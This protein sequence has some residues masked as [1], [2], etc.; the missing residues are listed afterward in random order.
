MPLKKS[1]GNM[2]PWVS[3]VHTHLGGECPH[4]CL[5]CYVDNPRWG[6]PARY[7]GALR[8]IEKEF[9]VDYGEGKTIF[10]ENC[11]DLFARE[12]LDDYI[13]RIMWHCHRYP[14]NTMYFRQ[15]TQKD[16]RPFRRVFHRAAFSERPSR[17]TATLLN[18][19]RLHV[20]KIA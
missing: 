14:L 8:L 4:K 16:L 12:V 18:S 7:Q 20:Q 2:Y 17:Q 5:Y 1:V 11:N 6:R 3:H 13:R 10:I 15:K 19:A 9:S